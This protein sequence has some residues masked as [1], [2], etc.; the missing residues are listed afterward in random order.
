[1][2]VGP[3]APEGHSYQQGRNFM[4][5]PRASNCHPPSS[6]YAPQYALFRAID[7]HCVVQTMEAEGEAPVPEEDEVTYF[8]N[9]DSA[10]WVQQTVRRRVYIELKLECTRNRCRDAQKSRDS[11]LC[12]YCRFSFPSKLRLTDHRVGGCQCG[13]VDPTGAKLELPVY[14]N[15]KTA[16][17]GK[18]LKAAIERGERSVWENLRDNS[19]WLELNP[20]LL[21]VTYPPT[22]AR[23]A[24]RRFMERTIEHLRAS[25]TSKQ[26]GSQSTS[27]PNRSPIR[28]APPPSPEEVVDLGDDATDEAEPAPS[29]PRKRSHARMEEGHR[30][31]TNHRQWH[32]ASRKP[33]PPPPPQTAQ[34]APA[35]PPHPIRVT[36]I[37]ARSPSPERRVIVAPPS[38][39][40]QAAPSPP[41]T[42]VPPMQAPRGDLDIASALRKERQFAYVKASAAARGS[43]KMDGPKPAL[44]PPIQPPGFFHL[45]PCGL[46]NFD[47]ETG[48]FHSFEEEVASWRSDP[49]CMDR[50]FAA[51]GRFS[52]PKHQVMVVTSPILPLWLHN[53]S[54]INR[55]RVL[56]LE[57]CNLKWECRFVDGNL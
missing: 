57:I 44:R 34:S 9:R 26:G 47:L 37:A 52:W 4:F 3:I 40:A 22:G 54:A 10:G 50:L 15:L 53:V 43:V 24:K 17:Q 35:P 12:V 30:V 25:H 39:V 16:K 51:F 46:L 32:S 42:P 28:N 49:A 48:D 56:W 38:P 55:F 14:P 18:D 6:N 1:M 36:P 27:R 8:V 41:V 7:L 45:L 13:P 23:V 33:K 2:A 19:M 29:Q 21:D 5:P 20:E 11:W 31:F